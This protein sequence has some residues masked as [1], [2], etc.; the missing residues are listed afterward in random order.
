MKAATKKTVLGRLKA[1]GRRGTPR[2]KARLAAGE[3]R[4][5]LTGRA[6]S[7]V[8]RGRSSASDSSRVL[9]VIPARYASSRFVG[10]PL[11]VIGSLPMI[12][13]VC[14]RA[15]KIRNADAVVVATDDY[16]IKAVVEE[17]GGAAIMTSQSHPTGTSRVA[18]AASKFPHGIIVN[19][20]GDEPLLPVRPVERLIDEMLS[21]ET[22]VM[23]TL[24]SP[25]DSPE[26]LARPDVVKVVGDRAGNALYFSRSPIPFAAALAPSGPRAAAAPSDARR[27]PRFLRHI[28]VYAFRRPFLFEFVHMKPGP[29]ET[30]ESLEQLR[31]LENG[32]A[33]RLVTCHSTSIGVDRPEDVKWVER[34]LR[35]R[36]GAP[37]ARRRRHS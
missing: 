16:R 10:K 2:P 23:G 37:A 26:D 22:L 15:E 1:K 11:A 36:S 14:R 24:A 5:S 21:D 32:Y 3:G 33:I 7:G 8:A 6:K 34:A 30:A 20:Q 28:G 31:A 12:V 19:V 4:G 25:A 13:H 27:A 29:L 18:E 17:A 9:V 35:N